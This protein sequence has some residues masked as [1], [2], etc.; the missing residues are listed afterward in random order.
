MARHPRDL[1]SLVFGLLLLAAAGLFLVSDLA[2]VALDLRWTGPGALIAAG[3]GGLVASS[4][5]RPTPNR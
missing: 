4:R 5:R 2:H 3:V 1:V